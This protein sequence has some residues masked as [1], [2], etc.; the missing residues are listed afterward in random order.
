MI[1]PLC[2]KEVKAVCVKR[3]QFVYAC[4]AECDC[5][6]V[7]GTGHGE[8]GAKESARSR[9][10]VAVERKKEENHR[11]RIKKYCHTVTRWKRRATR[12]KR[13]RLYN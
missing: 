6:E 8:R 2:E 11:P 13:A 12:T 9:F 5:I 7:K 4:Y 1:C 3:D 10:L